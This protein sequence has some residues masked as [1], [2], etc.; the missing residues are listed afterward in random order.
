MVAVDRPFYLTELAHELGG[1]GHQVNIYTRREQPG[2][3]RRYP[4]PGVTVDLIPAGPPRLLDS[5]EVLVHVGAFGRALAARWKHRPPDVVHAHGWVS[6]LAALSAGDLS[7]AAPMVQS[8]GQLASHDRGH[9]AHDR[10]HDA[11]GRGHDAQ[12]RT[13][14]QRAAVGSRARM[15][16]V[17]GRTAAASAVGCR[18]DKDELARLGVPRSRIRVLPGGVDIETFTERGP[19]YPHG[20]RTRLVMLEGPVPEDGAGVVVRALARVPGAELVIA[21]GPSPASLETDPGAHRLRLL[22]KTEG[23]DDRLILLGQVSR[24]QIPKL[25]RSADVMLALGPYDPYGTA[26][27]EAMACGVPLVASPAGSHLDTVVDGVNGVLVPAVTPVGLARVLRGL[28]ADPLQLAALGIAAADRARSRYSWP[29]I[30]TETIG[31]Y[32]RIS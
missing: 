2:V 14:T 7:R 19:A 29:R 32:E 8:Y 6:G 28:L 4:A 27:L 15:E 12:Q 10:G 25:L 22:A 21:G 23:V 1:Q 9:D 18:Q 13:P 26:A 5:G 16:R 30:A 3:R 20:T 24:R 31:V 17:L 11:H